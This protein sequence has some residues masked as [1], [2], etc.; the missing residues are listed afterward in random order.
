MKEFSWDKM[1]TFRYC[2]WNKSVFERSWTEEMNSHKDTTCSMR[3]KG[4]KEQNKFSN[5]FSQLNVN[6]FNIDIEWKLRIFIS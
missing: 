1:K 5:K 4:M 6:Q 3:F 2:Q